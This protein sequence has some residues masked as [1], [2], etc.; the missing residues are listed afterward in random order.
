M[1]ATKANR[2]V[3]EAAL[4]LLKSTYTDHRANR[5]KRRTYGRISRTSSLLGSYDVVAARRQGCYLR[6]VSI[7]E[8]YTDVLYRDLFVE[9]GLPADSAVQLLLDELD[10]RSRGWGD[11]GANF[12][13]FHKLKFTSGREWSR[14]E[15]TTH[16]RNTIAHGLGRLTARQRR[17]VDLPQKLVGIDVTIRDGRLVLTERSLRTALHVC[18]D[19]VRRLDSLSAKKP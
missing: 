16:A 11:R 7:V 3:T 15:A 18:E 2:A 4:R 1:T 9:A 8:A 17:N 13:V 5:G 10:K 19:F 6:L 12:K 14:Y